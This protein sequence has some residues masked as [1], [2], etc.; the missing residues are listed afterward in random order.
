MLIN[1]SGTNYFRLRPVQ[2]DIFLN[3]VITSFFDISTTQRVLTNTLNSFG[4]ADLT[5]QRNGVSSLQMTSSPNMVVSLAGL[6][7]DNGLSV[8]AGQFLSVNSII[9]SIK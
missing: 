1:V 7:C 5:F 3:K 2:D 9:K 8:P 4:D 6:R